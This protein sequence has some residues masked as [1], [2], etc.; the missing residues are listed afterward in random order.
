MARKPVWD[1]VAR[2]EEGR[3]VVRPGPLKPDDDKPEGL[4][5]LGAA[6]ALGA[7]ALGGRVLEYLRGRWGGPNS[8]PNDG[9]GPTDGEE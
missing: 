6:L 2:D 3:F 7:V 9:D 5:L 1:D 4:V 8:D